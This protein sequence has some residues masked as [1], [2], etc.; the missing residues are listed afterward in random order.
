LNLKLESLNRALERNENRRPSPRQLQNIEK[1]TESKKKHERL[2]NI[3]KLEEEIKFLKRDIQ[4]ISKK[5]DDLAFENEDLRNEMNRRNIAKF[6]TNL[7]SFAVVKI[8]S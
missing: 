4:S 6:Y 5:L 8:I 3:K 2:E 1:I 7:L